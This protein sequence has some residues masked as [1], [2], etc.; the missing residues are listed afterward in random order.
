MKDIIVIDMK[1]T[2]FDYATME[3]SRIME[4]IETQRSYEKIEDSFN[5]RPE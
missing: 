1:K 3:E 4:E 2:I 5:W